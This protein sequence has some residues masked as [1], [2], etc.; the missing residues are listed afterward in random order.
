[1]NTY[2]VTRTWYVQA[3]DTTNA[4]TQTTSQPAT[5]T[6]AHL[7]NQTELDHLAEQWCQEL[8]HA[9]TIRRNQHGDPPQ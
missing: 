1:M 6:H 8:D 4:I 9:Q 3:P 5:E 7:M 2:R